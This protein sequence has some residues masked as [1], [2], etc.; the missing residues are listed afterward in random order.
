MGRRCGVK[1]PPIDAGNE[2]LPLRR[3]EGTH[4]GIGGGPGEVSLVQTTL[5]EPDTGAIPDEELDPGAPMI[6]K[7]VGAAVAG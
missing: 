1:S 3:R 6:V 5:A 2:P 4:R 7:G